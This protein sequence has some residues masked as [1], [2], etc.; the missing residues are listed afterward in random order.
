MRVVTDAL[1]LFGGNGLTR[2]Y[3]MEK[4]FRDARAA[5]I[6][7]GENTILSTRLGF[8]LQQLY[9]EGWAQN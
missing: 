5:Q 8:L 2:E 6:E 4:L 1:Q 7:D 9:E 3:P